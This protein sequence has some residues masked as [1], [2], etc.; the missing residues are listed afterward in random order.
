MSLLSE[1]TLDNKYALVGIF[2][3]QEY[4]RA[5]EVPEVL[6]VLEVLKTFDF[7]T[8][9]NTRMYMT[10]LTD[11]SIVWKTP[12][13]K[14][15]HWLVTTEVGAPNFELRYIEIPPGVPKSSSASHPH[16][17]EVFIVKGRG[18]LQGIQDGQPCEVD[19][20]PGQAIF[21]PGGEDHQW[22]NPYEEPLGIICVVPKGAEAEVK[23]PAMK[24]EKTI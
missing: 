15:I 24:R 11:E 22:L 4:S 3:V 6:E 14:K 13:G 23:P 18:I 7:I 21:I 20:R 5:L 10:D 8:W 19:L 16:E 12:S 17:H 2:L 1:T 9:E